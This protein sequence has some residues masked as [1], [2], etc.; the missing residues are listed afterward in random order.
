MP[1]MTIGVVGFRAGTTVLAD[2]PN[3]TQ[4]VVR[5]PRLSTGAAGDVIR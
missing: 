1:A 4:V 5:R 3:L 2:R